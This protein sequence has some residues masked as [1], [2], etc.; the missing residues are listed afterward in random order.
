[1]YSAPRADSKC[2]HDYVPLEERRSYTYL[3]TNP[4]T[5]KCIV[6][7]HGFFGDPWSTWQQFQELLD[8]PTA[9]G[10]ELW[11]TTDA[12]FFDYGAE[13]DFVA[14]SSQALGEFL[15]K[16]Y[17]NPRGL[18]KSTAP[19]RFDLPYAQIL[20]VGHSLGAVVIRQCV[21]NVLNRWKLEPGTDLPSTTV[22]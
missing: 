11:S 20:L 3:S 4:L 8:I 16:L 13:K 14:R 6:F 5:N 12:Y 10:A 21:A 17:P 15:I 22:L 9:M 7:V 1:M 18:F 19:V 2:S